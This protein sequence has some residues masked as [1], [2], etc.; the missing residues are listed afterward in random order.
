MPIVFEEKQVTNKKI[1]LEPNTIKKL[2]YGLLAFD[3]LQKNSDS[4]RKDTPGV[5]QAK[6]VTSTDYRTDDK[7]KKEGQITPLEAERIIHHDK[8]DSDANSTFHQLFDAETMTDIKSKLKQVRTTQK[9]TL[10]QKDN[11]KT[12]T[13]I[14]TPTVQPVKAPKPNSVSESKKIH[15]NEAQLLKLKEY[16]DQLTLPFDGTN[17]KFNDEHFVDWLEDTGTYGQLPPS[18]GD[19]DNY[20][21]LNFDEAF[22]ILLS[23]ED[24]DSIFDE[25]IIYLREKCEKNNYPIENMFEGIDS[26]DLDS[27]LD[28][29]YNY[30]A[31]Q[32]YMTSETQDEFNAYM[33][34]L[35]EDKLNEFNPK[36]N[37]RGL[38][39]VEREIT[40]PNLLKKDVKND[41]LLKH[42]KNYYSALDYLY[43]DHIGQY[44]SWLYGKAYCGGSGDKVL[45]RGYVAPESVDWTETLAKQAYSLYEEREI[46][47]QYGKPIE[48]V[49]I[50]TK[51]GERLPIR[52]SIIMKA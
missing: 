24:N 48:I 1:Q 3:D 17:D 5:K 51:K 13:N 18:N 15:I 11:N 21:S 4:I 9:P 47:I 22:D 41:I 35:F 10:P 31:L 30:Y 52:G 25:F 42:H 33:E 19:I 2:K 8:Y 36:I 37:E 40:L 45:L 23:W 14:P 43:G 26:D 39:Y 28:Q 50:K 16:H 29:N 34:T 46:F 44:W 49:E 32:D 27:I 38:I 7:N 6:H 12:A 20:I